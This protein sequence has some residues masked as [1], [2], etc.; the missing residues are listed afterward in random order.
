MV[1]QRCHCPGCPKCDPPGG[2]CVR[3]AVKGPDEQYRACPECTAEQWYKAQPT[4]G[5]FLSPESP[6]LPDSRRIGAAYEGGAMEVSR[7]ANYRDPGISKSLPNTPSGTLGGSSA[8]RE[9][10]SIF[11][12]G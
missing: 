4:Y 2:P 12:R 7:P 10:V 5:T 3:W 11:P 8:P 1:T 9:W 6:F